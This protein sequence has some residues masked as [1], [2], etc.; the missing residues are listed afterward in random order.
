MGML[1]SLGS[2]LVIFV[3]SGRRPLPQSGSCGS[4][5]PCWPYFA[6]EKLHE[7]SRVLATH[8]ITGTVQIVLAPEALSSMN[9]SLKSPNSGWFW[10][11][12][13]LF[14]KN[15]SKPALVMLSL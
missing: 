12:L 7:L 6:T 2:L 10:L 8:P 5:L 13:A 1:L 11:A 15:Q 14:S 4:V 3:L 9:W